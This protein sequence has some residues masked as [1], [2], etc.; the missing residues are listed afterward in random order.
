MGYDSPSQRFV[1]SGI[2][3]EPLENAVVDLKTLNGKIIKGIAGVFSVKASDGLIYSCKAKGIFRKDKVKPVIG[4][5]VVIDV[6]SEN[7]LE[8]NITE[9]LE[10]RNLLIRPS[11]SNIDMA[12]VVAAFKNPNPNFM[13][14]DKL[15]LHFKQQG[16]P[17][18]LCFNKEDL[19]DKD[20]AKEYASIYCDSGVDVI[21][22]SAGT[23]QGIAGLK[24]MLNGK[25]TCIAGPSGVG[26]S[27][28]INALQDNVQMETGDISTKLKRGKHTTRHSEIIPICQDTFII[29]TPGFTS[30]EV[31][32]ITH[33]DLKDYY[34]EFDPFSQCYFTP[35]SHI[36]E[37]NCG[38]REALSEGKISRVRYDNYCSIYEELKRKSTIYR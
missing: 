28:I 21:A 27:T 30:I 13:M 2:A 18:V 1:Y 16:I 11:V 19:T 32:D 14:L 3:G 35:C 24:E 37:P 17:I 8:G 7:D 20:F 15:I 36:H 33:E 22:I 25:T 23:D 31:F 34:D 38:V 12:L 29:D 9:I 6:I 10:R 26:K 5:N 4:D